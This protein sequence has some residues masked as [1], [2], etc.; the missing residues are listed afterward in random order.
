M[1]AD[2]ALADVGAEVGHFICVVFGLDDG[3]FEWAERCDAE[4]GLAD[5]PMVGRL[6]GEDGLTDAGLSREDE[7]A[8]A[9]E[10]AIFEEGVW[11]V[12]FWDGVGEVGEG[13]C[14]GRGVGLVGL[15][16]DGG[17]LDGHGVGIGV[18][19]WILEDE[20]CLA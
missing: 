9:P 6:D 8:A 18:L 7:S 17:E 5:G 20:V 15:A 3:D 16:G 4:E 13:K 1:V 10:V 2:E 12:F 19:V 14:R 11:V